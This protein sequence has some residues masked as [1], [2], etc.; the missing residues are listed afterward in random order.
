M[1]FLILNAHSLDFEIRKKVYDS[2]TGDTYYVKTVTKKSGAQKRTTHLRVSPI[3]SV[4]RVEKV[5][6]EG[7]VKKPRNTDGFFLPGR[8]YKSNG[9]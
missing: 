8:K 5:T 2:E 1:C 9:D 4:R 6:K 3:G 7:K